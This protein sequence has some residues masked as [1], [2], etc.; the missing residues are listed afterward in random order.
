MTAPKDTRNDDNDSSKLVQTNRLNNT[1]T[2]SFL[3]VLLTNTIQQIASIKKKPNEFNDG[4]KSCCSDDYCPHCCA[5]RN[6]KVQYKEKVNTSP[7]R[8]TLVYK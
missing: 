6:Y 7:R 3:N 5:V 8:I 1:A 2:T 4:M